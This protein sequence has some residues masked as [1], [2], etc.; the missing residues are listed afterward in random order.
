M[1]PLPDELHLT[2][3]QDGLRLPTA[4]AAQRANALELLNQAAWPLDAGGRKRLLADVMAWSGGMIAPRATHRVLTD[5]EIRTLAG[6]PGHD[7][8][9]HSVHHLALTT[10]PPA[11][12]EK[13]IGD[14]RAALEKLLQRPVHL[15]SYPYGDF[16]AATVAAVARAGFRAA[17]TVQPGLV[18]AGINR[19]LLPR[20]EVTAADFGRFPLRLQEMFADYSA[21]PSGIG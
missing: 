3:G 4:T 13:E 5:T 6:R 18:K 20:Y 19:L 10:Q 7:I 11:T 17:V 1:T 15:F 8:G 14:D 16:N 9:S 2:V 21:A 12:V